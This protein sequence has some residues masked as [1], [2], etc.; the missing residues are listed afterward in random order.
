MI[1]IMSIQLWMMNTSA[2]SATRCDLWPQRDFCIHRVPTSAMVSAR[3]ADD[4]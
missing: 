2:G 1:Y 3:K 4:H